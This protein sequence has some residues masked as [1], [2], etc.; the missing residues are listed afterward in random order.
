MSLLPPHLPYEGL[1][2]E[3]LLKGY[4]ACGAL[5]THQGYERQQGYSEEIRRRLRALSDD[6]LSAAYSDKDW[7]TADFLQSEQSRRRTAREEDV[8][9][10]WEASCRKRYQAMTDEELAGAATIFQA[11]LHGQK[12][13]KANNARF[14]EMGMVAEEQKRRSKVFEGEA[15]K[16]FANFMFFWRKLKDEQWV[17]VVY[18]VVATVLF[19]A[20]VKLGVKFFE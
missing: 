1:S 7:N 13:T 2:K 20:A 11:E 4:R 10:H 3:E 19:L 12:R 8:R 15:P 18:L 9:L 16:L 14:L 17:G 6:E 5:Q